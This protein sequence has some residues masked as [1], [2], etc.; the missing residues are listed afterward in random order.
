M[1]LQAF[2]PKEGVQRYQLSA[3]TDNVGNRHV[4]SRLLTTKFPL[5][6][7]LMRLAWELHEKGLD[8]RL[9]WLPGKQMRVSPR[10]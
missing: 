2:G 7:I 9:D 6:V 8:L 4:L 5:C 1:S 3:G 10:S